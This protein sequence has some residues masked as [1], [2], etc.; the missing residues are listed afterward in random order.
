MTSC[1]SYKTEEV[2]ENQKRSKHKEFIH[3]QKRH[4]LFSRTTFSIPAV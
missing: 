2:C 1:L 3:N 4:T